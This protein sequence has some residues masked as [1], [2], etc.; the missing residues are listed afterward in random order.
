MKREL[1]DAAVWPSRA[2][3]RTTI[4]DYI[5]NW[6][7]LHRLH[8]NLGYRSPVNYEATRAA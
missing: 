7:N 8:S 3:A 5:K 6:Y 4:F 2:A 1:L